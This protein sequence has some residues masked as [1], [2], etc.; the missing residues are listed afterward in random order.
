MAQITADMI[1]GTRGQEIAH[2]KY[3]K[4]GYGYG[5]RNTTFPRLSWIERSYKGK[6][7]TEAGKSF[8]RSFYVDGISVADLDAAA[9]ALSQPPAV[10]DDEKAA[11]ER[12]GDRWFGPRE[13]EAQCLP[14]GDW[15]A[16]HAIMHSLA[17]K[18]LIECKWFPEDDPVRTKIKA[19]KPMWRRAP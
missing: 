16:R 8:D 5:F 4:G 9:V 13:L 11:L 18:G 1:R 15:K 7:A 2:Y 14:A 17:D 19:T 12:I 6:D 3:G 10:T